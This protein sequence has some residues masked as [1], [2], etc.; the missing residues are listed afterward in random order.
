MG[1]KLRLEWYDKQ[2]ERYQGEECSKDLGDDES[3]L[4][5]LDI[6]AENNIN[7][8][9]FNVGRHWVDIIQP[10][11]QHPI[12]LAAHDYQIAFDYR[13]TW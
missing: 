10:Y 1:L 6:P 13:E 12:N 4:N 8:G 9:G 11:F 5:A 2:T 7:N 3:V